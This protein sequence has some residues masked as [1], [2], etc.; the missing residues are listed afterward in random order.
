LPAGRKSSSAIPFYARLRGKS[1]KA[2]SRRTWAQAY[3][4]SAS[5]LAKSL[6]GA[7]AAKIEEMLDAGTIEEICHGRKP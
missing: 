5:L 1:S 7:T 4:R 6:E 3:A 2:N